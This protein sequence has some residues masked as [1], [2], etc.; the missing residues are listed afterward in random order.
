MKSSNR[1]PLSSPE[2]TRATMHHHRTIP[3]NTC[4]RSV[5]RFGDM[6]RSARCPWCHPNHSGT[7]RQPQREAGSDMR[8]TRQRTPAVESALAEE[9]RAPNWEERTQQSKWAHGRPTHGS[10]TSPNRTRSNARGTMRCEH[11][12][13]HQM[14]R[15]PSESSANKPAPSLYAVPENSTRAGAVPR[16]PGGARH[17]GGNRAVTSQP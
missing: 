11:C 5:C 9:K 1:E 15:T 2:C 17:G 13:N 7:T 10:E 14:R 4:D 12:S 16:A 8:P 3:T 6:C